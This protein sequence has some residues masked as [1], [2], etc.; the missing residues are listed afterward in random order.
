MQVSQITGTERVL[1]DP[2][3]I[4]SPAYYY[5]VFVNFNRETNSWKGPK[6]SLCHG[7]T[8]PSTYAGRSVILCL[9]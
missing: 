2:C 9:L 3:V 1:K 7:R 5:Y 8:L 6:H 4:R